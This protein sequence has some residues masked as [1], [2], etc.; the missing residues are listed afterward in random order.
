MKILHVITSLGSGGAEGMLYRL[1]QA[2]SDTVE[3]SVIC[4]NKGGKYVSFLREAGIDVLVLD[5][6]FLN[7]LKVLSHL[8]QFSRSKKKQGYLIITSWLL[9]ADM[10]AWFIKF[11]CG[12]QGL[13]WNIRNSKLQ[14][15]QPSFKNWLLLKILATLSHYGVNQIISNSN[16][17]REIH[18]KLGYRFDNFSIIPN[19]YFID[20]NKKFIKKYKKYDGIYRICIVARWSNQ[21]NFENLF[22]ALSLLQISNIDFH[23]T[24]A[25]YQTGPDNH[26]LTSMLKKYK[27]NKF[28][29]LIGEVNDVDNIYMKSHVTVLSSSYGEAFPNVLAESMLNFTPCIATNVGDTSDILEGVGFTVP[30]EDSIALADALNKYLNILRDEEDIYYSNCIKCF[31]K[32]CR[33]YDIKD[34][35]RSYK[36]LWESLI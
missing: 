17:A 3:H 15:G 30:I 18:K 8:L 22:K 20:I 23:L 21:K 25:G 24:I 33:Y 36:N 32:I 14:R 7:L 28:C 1:I 16:S 35:A 12:F 4:I 10:I 5:F 6:K 34:I 2:S 19:G 27:I 11:T 9:H 26:E 29:S 13:V 31:E